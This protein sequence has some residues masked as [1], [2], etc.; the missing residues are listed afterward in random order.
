L[1]TEEREMTTLLTKDRRARRTTGTSPTE[2]SPERRGWVAMAIALLAVIVVAGIVVLL[3]DVGAGGD[4]PGV[5]PAESEDEALERLVNEGY[6]PKG[7]LEDSGDAP[8]ATEEAEES[9]TET[10]PPVDAERERLRSR[11]LLPE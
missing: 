10:A 3:Y 6:I 9:S 1:L 8:A 2:P 5:R 11:G 7:A 4:E